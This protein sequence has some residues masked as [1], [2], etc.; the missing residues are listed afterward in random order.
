MPGNS[1]KLVDMAG[2]PLTPEPR[3]VVIK[4]PKDVVLPPQLLS[5]LSQLLKVTVIE[6][7]MSCEVL[8]GKLAL[9]ELQAIHANIHA[10]L[11][12]LGEEVK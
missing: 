3:I 7:P 8:E 4:V 2:R 1:G 10:A 9:G 12:D 6:L 11:K 5:R